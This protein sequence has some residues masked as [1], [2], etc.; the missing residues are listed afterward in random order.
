MSY[1]TPLQT[2]ENWQHVAREFADGYDHGD[3]AG[4]VEASASLIVGGEEKAR[5]EFM[6]D[7][8]GEICGF[9]TFQMA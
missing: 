3:V 5:A 4:D 7:E 1:W 9:K 2:G 8:T 6:F